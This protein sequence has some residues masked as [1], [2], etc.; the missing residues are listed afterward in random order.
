[1]TIQFAIIFGFMIG[2]TIVGIVNGYF[3][4]IGFGLKWKW[5]QSLENRKFKKISRIVYPTYL[6]T[7]EEI[8]L[9]I[10]KNYRNLP[11]EDEWKILLVKMIKELS[12]AGWNTEI[13]IQSKFK[14]GH[15]DIWVI[16]EDIDLNIKLNKIIKKYLKIYDTR[17]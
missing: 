8:E 16:T 2:L 9:Y 6:K 13:P 4:N 5:K 11:T 17:D 10:K 7:D 1:M 12:N 14:Y 3:Q 15:Y